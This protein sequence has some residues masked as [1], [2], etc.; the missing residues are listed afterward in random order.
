MITRQQFEAIKFLVNC[1]N[2][3]EITTVLLRALSE[4]RPDA[5]PDVVGL[6]GDMTKSMAKS[7]KKTLDHVKHVF[8]YAVGCQSEIKDEHEFIIAL[9]ACKILFP[10]GVTIN[11]SP[12]ARKYYDNMLAYLKADLSR[13][14]ETE[15]AE[16]DTE[17]Y[18]KKITA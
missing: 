11:A 13:F 8:E 14:Q 9:E 2:I 18:I 16:P 6:I 10:D 1:K 17:A 4:E 12:A 15:W 7:Q 3:A 5:V